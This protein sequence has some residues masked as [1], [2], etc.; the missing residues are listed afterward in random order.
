[1]KV[2]LDKQR[3][4]QDVAVRDGVA[5]SYAPSKRAFPWIRWCLVVL[6][7]TS[8]LLY[9]LYRLASDWL[10]VTS[11][12]VVVLERA[13]VSMPVSGKIEGLAVALDDEVRRGEVLMRVTPATYDD[14]LRNLDLLR[15]R[16][17]DYG[18]VPK[19][20]QAAAAPQPQPR[21]KV[22]EEA[23]AIAARTL[24][25]WRGN[26]LAFEDLQRKGAATEAE[27]REALEREQEARS[28]LIQLQEAHAA[29]AAPQQQSPLPTPTESR[30][31]LLE[32]MNID[33]EIALLEKRLA[34]HVVTS[35]V[36]GKVAKVLAGAGQS[37]PLGANVLEIVGED[38]AE[39]RVFA[40]ERAMGYFRYGSAITVE[41]PGDVKI[42]CELPD[43]PIQTS[44]PPAAPDRPFA[45]GNAIML[46]LRPLAPLPDQYR[47]DGLPVTVRW[48]V[49][50]P[51][52]LRR[53]LPAS[54]TGD[55]QTA[56][57]GK[58]GR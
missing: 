58:K 28:A 18:R 52:L 54:D 51:S 40:D 27:Y 24:E 15:A 13:T 46:H 4:L 55:G 29:A 32:R 56:F 39:I 16:V 7:V 44:A 50:K 53:L 21:A 22:S 25:Y 2:V 43:R 47:V 9:I 49:W 6:L 42:R 11:P 17:D 36:T 38:G 35:P 31:D 45:E 33:N 57:K 37:L 20:V 5:V 41:L 23:L 34:P 30:A 26:R 3:A 14:D 8:P 19:L 1:M 12:A 10:L 48:G